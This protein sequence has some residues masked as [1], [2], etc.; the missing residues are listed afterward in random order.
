MGGREEALAAKRPAGLQDI[1]PE[2]ADLLAGNDVVE[3][4]VGKDVLEEVGG[5]ADAWGSLCLCLRD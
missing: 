5:D 4:K 3:V 1:I 2:A